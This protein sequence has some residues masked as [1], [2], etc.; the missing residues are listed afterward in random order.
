MTA[1]E[2]VGAGATTGGAEADGGGGDDDA[3]CSAVYTDATAGGR[4]GT[5]FA[6]A[7]DAG[8]GRGGGGEAASACP[9][10]VR[11][12]LSVSFGEE[13][14]DDA[15]DVEDD[16]DTGGRCLCI[17]LPRANSSKPCSSLF[18]AKRVSRSRR[19]AALRASFSANCCSIAL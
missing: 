14:G 2:A 4:H 12:F 16:D 19:S 8:G 7:A 6:E 18:W 3:P 5:A 13:D 15:D 1:G 17:G 11:G 10:A 9:L